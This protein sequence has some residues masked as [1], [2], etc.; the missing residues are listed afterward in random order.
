[1]AGTGNGRSGRGAWHLVRRRAAVGLSLR[2]NFN[3]KREQRLETSAARID[4]PGVPYSEVRGYFYNLDGAP[5]APILQNG[6]LHETVVDTNGARL[7]QQQ[8]EQ[9][10]DAVAR[11]QPPDP[12]A[13]CYMPRH[14]FIFYDSSQTCRFRRDLLRLFDYQT[15]PSLPH[16][17]NLS[18]LERLCRDVGLPVLARGKDYRVFKGNPQKP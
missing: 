17:I 16:R 13:S 9:L 4:W 11:P 7:T 6:H 12:V 18:A 8:I 5:G 10:L 14:A 15:S 3:A 2:K 1:M